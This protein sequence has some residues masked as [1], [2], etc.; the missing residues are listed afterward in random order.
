MTPAFRMGR[1]ASAAGAAVMFRCFRC[2]R[3]LLREPRWPLALR[4][5]WAMG[6]FSGVAAGDPQAT[7]K[8][9]RTPKAPGMKNLVLRI[10][11][12]VMATLLV[13]FVGQIPMSEFRNNGWSVPW[14][15]YSRHSLPFD[16]ESPIV[17]RS[18]MI[19]SVA[20]ISPGRP[21]LVLRVPLRNRLGPN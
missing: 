18:R 5:P 14:V 10:K 7:T 4:W 1:S 20:C 6:V 9:N 13:D 3:S 2:L 11:S 12:L 15:G 19:G 21:C 8:A 16:S 17:V